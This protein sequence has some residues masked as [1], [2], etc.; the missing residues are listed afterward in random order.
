MCFLLPA[1]AATWSTV[2]SSTWTISSIE[3][4]SY[5][6]S[7]ALDSNGQP[8]ISYKDQQ[9]DDLKYAVWQ[10]NSWTTTTVDSKYYAGYSPSLALDS[11]GQPHISYT[12]REPLTYTGAGYE[13]KEYLK[14]AVKE[15]SKW[16]IT[17]LD[18]AVYCS[19]LKLDSSNQPHISYGNNYLKYAVWNGSSWIITTADSNSGVNTYSSLALDSNNRPH[20]CY[21]D[22]IDGDKGTLNYAKLTETGWEIM[23]VDSVGNGMD[24]N[25]V[26]DSHDQPHISYSD[27]VTHNFRYAVLENDSWNIT[28]IDSASEVTYSSLALD[29]D[30]RPHITYSDI[31]NDTLKY[32]RFT[33]TNWEIMTVDSGFADSSLVLDSDDRP[34]IAYCANGY[35]KY[36]V[37]DN[38]V[39]TSSPPLREPLNLQATIGNGNVT[40]SWSAPS[41]NVGQSIL[42]YKIYRGT[43]SGSETFLAIVGNTTTYT[44]AL[45]DNNVAYYYRVSAVNTEGE[46]AKSNQATA[47][48]NPSNS[49]N[50]PEYPFNIIILVIALILVLTL[51]IVVK[52][53]KSVPTLYFFRAWFILRCSHQ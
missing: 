18:D 27:K 38:A 46:G 22:E 53:A 36:A 52:K 7:L 30:D 40:L 28:P 13:T 32:A 11:N 1:N 49:P 23:A 34:H 14:Y 39:V 44:D 6:P 20:I 33:G 2:K 26:L 29:S 45:I 51:T 50:I 8:H 3:Y 42:N 5:D 31:T 21:L 10:G 47:A 16:S 25:L 15:G 48:L 35:L 9:N 4:N 24:I 17:T 41:L 37:L 43:T 12:L 19:S